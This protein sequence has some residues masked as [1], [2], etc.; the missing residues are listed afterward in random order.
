MKRHA[1]FTLIELLAVIAIILLIVS[2]LAPALKGARERAMEVQCKVHLRQ[3]GTAMFTFAQE[4]QGI[5]PAGSVAYNDGDEPWQ[6]CW[7]GK[8]V[9]PPGIATSSVWPENRDGVLMPYIGN[10][11]GIAKRMYRCQSLPQGELGSGLGSNGYFDYS[12]VMF[13]SGASM[14]FI[15]AKAQFRL[16]PSDSATWVS[17]PTPLVVEEDPYWWLNRYPN[18]EPGC[19]NQDRIGVWHR[20]R[21]FYLATDGSAN[22]CTPNRP[23]GLNPSLNDIYVQAPSGNMQ[24]IGPYQVYGGWKDR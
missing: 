12:M 8:E 24:S 18:V 22:E 13:F 4:H 23:D 7:M 1:G 5:L 10:D 11:P 15:P 19:G 16:N 6:K 17:R 14:A 2:L 9:L 21:G 20:G 3:I